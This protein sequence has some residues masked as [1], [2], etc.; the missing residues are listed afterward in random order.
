MRAQ[1]IR[2]ED[3]K[4]T[5]DIGNYRSNAPKRNIFKKMH[6]LA[7]ACP[8]FKEVTEIDWDKKEPSFRIF[9][10]KTHKKT[11]SI[12]KEEFT[13]YLTEEE[14]AWIILFDDIDDNKYTDITLEEFKKITSCK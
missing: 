12:Y 13:L 5:M 3:P 6:Q 8:L 4:E 7:E 9:S 2:G 14:E 10:T 1:F 11:P